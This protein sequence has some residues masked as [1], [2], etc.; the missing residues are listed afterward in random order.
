MN[1]ILLFPKIETVRCDTA[2]QA[3]LALMPL[4]DGRAKGAT[5]VRHGKKWVIKIVYWESCDVMA[6]TVSNARKE[7][8][9]DGR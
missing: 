1:N 2:K 9:H 8:C 4:H 3:D 7:W 6:Q 5:A